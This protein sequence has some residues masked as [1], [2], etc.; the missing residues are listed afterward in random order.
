MFQHIIKALYFSVICVTKTEIQISMQSW[1]T[2]SPPIKV[3]ETPGR[4][5]WR[6]RSPSRS[7][8]PPS[9]MWT[10]WRV[11]WL[12]LHSYFLFGSW[13]LTERTSSRRREDCHC[14]CW[15]CTT[16]TG[17]WWRRRPAAWEES[18]A[19][20]GRVLPVAGTRPLPPTNKRER[21]RS[22]TSLVKCL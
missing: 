8:Y 9:S 13:A 5:C 14:G 15:L 12:M 22:S 10:N 3:K 4:W 20:R 17:C 19:L 7:N 11:I 16:S 21:P 2:C 18:A 6:S 1:A